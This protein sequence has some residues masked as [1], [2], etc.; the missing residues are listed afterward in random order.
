MG[1]FVIDDELAAFLAGGNS[2]L[3][4][5]RDAT[6]A[7]ESTRACALRVLAPDRIAVLLPR[8]TSARSIANL[9][10]N[11]EIAVCVSDPATFRSVQLK[12]RCAGID[13]ASEEDV[14]LSEQ[15]FRGFS[16]AVVA[17]GFTPAHTRNLWLFE[18]WRVEVEITAAFT[19]TPGPGAGARL[20]ARDAG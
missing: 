5:T 19:Q 15:Q 10:D 7:P 18:S 1:A 14:L 13:D 4:A 12:G 16:D 17:F 9:E 20:P 11:G 6:L 3:V 8:A 2:M